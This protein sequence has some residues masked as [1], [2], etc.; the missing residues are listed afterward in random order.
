MYR[1]SLTETLMTR[2]FARITPDIAAD[3]ND[4]KT[5]LPCHFD[6]RL[7]PCFGSRLQ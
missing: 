7:F 4:K 2:D 5:T 1:L 6:G 3:I